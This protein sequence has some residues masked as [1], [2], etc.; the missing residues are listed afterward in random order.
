ME[1]TV[2]LFTNWK[3][4]KKELSVSGKTIELISIDHVVFKDVYY[5]EVNGVTEH[6]Q[7][8]T[9]KLDAI[10]NEFITEEFDLVYGR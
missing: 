8:G 5:I 2:E 3:I 10:F 1:R 4:L 6:M 7:Y 9:R